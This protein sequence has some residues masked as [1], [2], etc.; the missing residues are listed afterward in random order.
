MKTTR[1]I[2]LPFSPKHRDTR[3]LIVASKSN[4][5]KANLINY[6]TASNKQSDLSFLFWIMRIQHYCNLEISRIAL[7]VIFPFILKQIEVNPYASN[8]Q[9]YRHQIYRKVAYPHFAFTLITECFKDIFKQAPTFFCFRN[10]GQT[11]PA[12][13]TPESMRWVCPS[14]W[15]YTETYSRQLHECK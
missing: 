10:K 9:N 12:L 3:P 13:P 14:T 1:H 15:E 4:G 2:Q 7:H 11:I 5:Q 8:S 6:Q